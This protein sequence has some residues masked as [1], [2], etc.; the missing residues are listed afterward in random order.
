M[1]CNI[2]YL[3]VFLDVSGFSPCMINLSRNKTLCCG[4]KKG[5]AKSRALVYSEQQILALLLVLHR[6][7]NLSRNKCGHIRSTPS[8]STSV[9]HFFNLQQILLLRDRLITQGERHET[10]IQNLQRNNVARQVEGFCISYLAAVKSPN[11]RQETDQLALNKQSSEELNQRLPGTNPANYLGSMPGKN[12][13]F[14]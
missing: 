1:L 6:T 11:C 3:Q 9:L 13:D 8:K 12:I 2:A 10:L 14:V 7:Q 4:L 5:V